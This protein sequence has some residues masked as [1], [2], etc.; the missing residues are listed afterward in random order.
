MDY[1]KIKLFSMMQVK[2]AYL[3]E[4]QDVISQNIANA[5]TPGYKAKQLHELDFERLARAEAHRLEMRATSPRHSTGGRQSQNFRVET[6]RETFETTPVEN[7][8][9]IE[10]QMAKLSKN[11]YE[12]TMTT[13][14]Y[15]KTSQMF[16]T[17][18]GNK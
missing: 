14:L 10:E 16:K 4:G 11:Q 18:I 3:A 12:Y 6:Q 1:S 7:S 15:N 2:M 17:A 5:D 8:I 9:S 13:N